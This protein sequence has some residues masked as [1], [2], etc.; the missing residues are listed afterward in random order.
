MEKEF[1]KDV[2]LYDRLGGSLNGIREKLPYIE[3]IGVNCLWLSP[4]FESGSHHGYDVIDYFKVAEH[5]GGNVALKRLVKEAH[6]CNIRIILDFVPNHCSKDHPY[7]KEARSDI[8]SPYRNWFI[9]HNWPGEYETFMGVKELPKLNLQ[10]PETREYI[11]S[12]AEMWIRDYQIDVLRLDYTN[13]P[14]HD[15]WTDFQYRIKML[16]SDF[17]TVG[18]IVEAP[19]VC[20][21]L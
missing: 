2:S 7:F 1:K 18:E 19:E 20:Y 13:D 14:W 8:R 16:K 9:F 4:V 6:K 12:A 10:N 15:F 17:F 21:Y 11:L 3:S 5:F